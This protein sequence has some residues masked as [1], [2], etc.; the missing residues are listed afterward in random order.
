MSKQTVIFSGVEY[1]IYFRGRKLLPLHRN[2]TFWQ[3]FNWL[4]SMEIWQQRQYSVVESNYRND[5]TLHSMHRIG[6]L[7]Y[8]DN[9]PERGLHH[10][11]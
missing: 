8:A 11:R 1:T 4:R 9:N 10:A 2:L 3:V 7:W 5:R 6:S